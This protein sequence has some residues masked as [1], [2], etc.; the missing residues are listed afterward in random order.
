MRAVRSR[1]KLPVAAAAG[2]LVLGACAT[3]PQ[4]EF[5]DGPPESTPTG[6]HDAGGDTATE[7]PT[8]EHTASEP[9]ESEPAPEPVTLSEVIVRPGGQ[10][11]FEVQVGPLVRDGDHAVLPLSFSPVDELEDSFPLQAMLMA[12]QYAYATWQVRL[13]DGEA[14]TISEPLVTG[15]SNDRDRL[16]TFPDGHTASPT[17]TEPVIWFGGFDAPESESSNVLLPYFGL[18]EDVPIVDGPLDGVPAISELWDDVDLAVVEPRT[19]ELERYRERTDVHVGTESEGDRSTTTLATDVLF[20]PDEWDLTGEADATLQAAIAEIGGADGGGLQIVGHTD[21]VD[22]A[23]DNQELS[24]NRAAAVRDRLEDL[25]DLS[26]FDEVTT[27]GRADSE[28]IAGNDSDE[29]RAANRRVELHYTSPPEPPELDPT[30]D[31]ELPPTE[32]PTAT[33]AEGVEVTNPD[34]RTANVSVESV[35]RVGD[36]FVGRITVE[37]LT[38]FGEDGEDHDG[39]PISWPLTTGVQGTQEGQGGLTAFLRTDAPTLL[40]GNTRLFPV[41]YVSDEHEDGEVTRLPATDLHFSGSAYLSGES[42][43]A[44][45]LWPA[46]NTDTLTVDSPSETENITGIARTGWLHPWR[47]T[48]VPVE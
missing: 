29:G 44:T 33:G 3:D 19:F 7:T 12:N 38:G 24:D 35:H 47:L 23:V 37:A 41:T 30:A 39:V 13:V 15:E 43:T 16:A 11:E 45:I 36:L 25:M 2:V 4:A 46:L 17:R 28:P 5:E 26:V 6:D 48:D 34:G 32:G 27:A 8:D 18:A 1:T 14:L 20:A 22:G 10:A 42:A 21:N 40:A 31:A 9:P